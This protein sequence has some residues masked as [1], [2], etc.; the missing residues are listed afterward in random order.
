M[1]LHGQE[2]NVLGARIAHELYGAGMSRNNFAPVLADH[3]HPVPVYGVEIGAARNKRDLLARCR[4]PATQ[5]A[6]DRS[7]ADNRNLHRVARGTLVPAA[8]RRARI[9]LSSTSAMIAAPRFSAAIV[10]N[11]PFQPPKRAAITLLIG[12]TSDAVPLAV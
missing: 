4:Q 10:T 9:G 7:S 3:A 12:T 1:R 5:Q 2:D 6:A 11:T 8:A